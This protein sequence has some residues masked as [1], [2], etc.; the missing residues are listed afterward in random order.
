VQQS[1]HILVVDDEAVHRDT[2]SVLLAA[3]GMRVTCCERAASA[4]DLLRG[5]QQFDLIISD[6]VMPGMDGIEFADEARRVRPGIPLILVTGHDS[7]TDY[8]IA[9]GNI[10]LLKPYSADALKRVLDDQ[11]GRAS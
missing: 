9:G 11:L 2:L 8:V 3:Q 4:L 10:A 1:P 6:V 7:A 5:K